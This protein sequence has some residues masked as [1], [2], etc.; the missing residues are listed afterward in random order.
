MSRES[1]RSEVERLTLQLH[2]MI[3]DGQGESADADSVREAILDRWD[4]LTPAN[5]ELMNTEPEPG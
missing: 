4:S 1:I 3:R 5:Q 2:T